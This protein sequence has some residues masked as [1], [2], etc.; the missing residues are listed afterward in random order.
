MLHL[1][2]HIHFSNFIFISVYD[3]YINNFFSWIKLK[4][5]KKEIAIPKWWSWTNKCI[6]TKWSWEW[7]TWNK[8]NSNVKN[9]AGTIISIKCDKVNSYKEFSKLNRRITRM[10]DDRKCIWWLNRC[11]VQKNWQIDRNQ[12]W[13]QA[14]GNKTFVWILFSLWLWG[15]SAPN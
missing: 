11:Y 8:N 14:I 7:K 12:Q 1:L 6:W 10:I 13:I 15:A 2:W 5:M 4:K 3:C 9:S